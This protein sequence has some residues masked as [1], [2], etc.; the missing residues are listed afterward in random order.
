LQP[1]GSGAAPIWAAATLP[2]VG[3][4]WVRL[5]LL[6]GVGLS[7]AA[8]AGP[9]AAASA[10]GALLDGPTLVQ[11]R[12]TIEETNAKLTRYRAGR[13]ALHGIRGRDQRESPREVGK[14]C[15]DDGQHL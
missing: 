13:L 8:T 4:D 1:A 3:A 5:P 9:P 15:A 2:W 10:T 14:L 6:C 12:R 11:A 7:V